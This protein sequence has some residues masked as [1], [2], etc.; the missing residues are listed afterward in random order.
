ME[1]GGGFGELLELAASVRSEGGLV[2]G[3]A[4]YPSAWLTPGESHLSRQ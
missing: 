1:P 4:P 3:Y 2:K